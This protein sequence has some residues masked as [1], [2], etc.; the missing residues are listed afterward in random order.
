MSAHD[1]S[2]A[3][4]PAAG[5]SSS[6]TPSDTNF[7]KVLIGESLG[8]LTSAQ[9]GF[10]SSV[11]IIESNTDLTG[12]KLRK[13]VAELFPPAVLFGKEICNLPA[14]H[15]ELRNVLDSRGANLPQHSSHRVIK[16]LAHGLYEETED[17]QEAV[18]MARAVIAAGRH[19][20][21]DLTNEAPSQSSVPSAHAF[22]DG[23][24]ATAGRLAHNVAMPKRKIEE[25]LR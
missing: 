15:I 19:P 20:R 11:R 14:V 5:A 17:T 24:R 13:T 23:S 9:K 21:A 3:A 8:A 4:E 6:S 18:E 10:I 2:L 25:V 7:M 12:Q 16:T 1:D 22:N